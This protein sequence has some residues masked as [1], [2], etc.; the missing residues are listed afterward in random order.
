MATCCW[1]WHGLTMSFT[2]T[3][4]TPALE[5]ATVENGYLVLPPSY[6]SG[7]KAFTL[8]IHGFEPRYISPHPYTNQR[9][10]ALARGPL[11]YCVEDVD[12]PWEQDH[13]RNVGISYQ[14]AVSEE[15]HVIDEMGERYVGLRAVGW[16]RKI[17]QWAQGEQGLEPG[18]S[19]AADLPEAKELFFIPYYLR[20]NRGGRGHM[21]VGLLSG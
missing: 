13:F 7:N 20:A 14:T 21:R 6:T 19:V 15:E 9:T 18:S 1:P 3:Q 4:L 8:Q 10:F 16:V 11:I 2:A 12:N 5:S 17:G